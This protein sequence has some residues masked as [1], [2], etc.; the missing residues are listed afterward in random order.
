M[1]LVTKNLNPEQLKAV[2]A[3]KGPLLILAGAG[4]GKTRVLTHRIANLIV[5]G[6]AQPQNILAVTFT[7][8]A[9]KEMRERALSLLHKLDIYPTQPPHI[10]TFHSFCVQV[11]RS[12]IHVLDYNPNF[13][14]YDRADQL[15]LVKKIFR[16]LNLDS[17]TYS[18]QAFLSTINSSKIYGVTPEDLAKEAV[19]GVDK[20]MAEVYKLYET[21]MKDANALDFDDLLLKTILL[22]E[23]N[24][25]VLSFYQDELKFIMVDEYQ[26]TSFIQYKLIQ[27]LAKAH[28]NLCA[29]GDEDQ[30][31]YSWRG[32]NIENILNFEKDFPEAKVIKLE[33][34]YRSTKVIVSAASE[35]IKNNSERKDKTLFTQ[36]KEGD[37]IIAR[38]VASEYDEGKFVAQT[39]QGIMNDHSISYDDIAIFYRTNSQSRAIEEELRSY[40]IPYQIIGGLKFYDRLEIK[41]LIAYMR[42]VLNPNDDVSF[43]RVLNTPTRGIGNVTEGKIIEYAKAHNLTLMR[44]TQEMANGGVFNGGTTKKLQSFLNIVEYLRVQ[45]KENRPADF[46]KLMVDHLQFVEYLKF[47]KPDD[48]SQRLEN[49]N[50]LTNVLVKF[51]KERGQEATLKQFL[52]EVSLVSDVDELDGAQHSI[53]MMTLHISKGLEYPYVFIVGFEDGIFPSTQS[54][55]S[56]DPALLEEERRLCYVGMTRAKEKLF[57]SFTRKRMQWGQEQINPPSRFLKEIPMQYMEISSNI[58][59]PKN[60]Q[61]KGDYGFQ[62]TKLDNPF[63]DY[64]DTFE[65][66]GHSGFKKGMKVRHPSFGIGTIHQLEGQGEDQKITI[67]F[68]NHSMKKFIL[69]YA[70]LERV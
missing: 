9:A 52:E 20:K 13:T 36:N 51:E 56:M 49:I 37:K 41:D 44:A 61:I 47:E 70:R 31:I 22:F 33:E 14:I 65:E 68:A 45:V 59:R 16:Q 10:A 1:N 58:M 12:Y 5:Q 69:K 66:T 32:A 11:L 7:N 27:L 42:L 35:V 30:S 24:P 6:L 57:L 38:E 4:S 21:Q 64:E 40:R 2:E 54:V 18:A 48:Y 23:K 43:M 17:K 62:P 50:E 25:E 55:E 39:I 28:R 60:F 15:S 63:P 67:L 53:K 34:N 26:D 46:L 19:H 29:V 3:L 8:K